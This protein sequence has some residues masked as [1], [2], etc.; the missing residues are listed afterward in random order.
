MSNQSFHRQSPWL[1]MISAAAILMIT[2]G[3]RQS[4][5]LF[6]SPLVESTGLSIASVSFAMAVGQLMWGVAQ[7]IFGMVADKWGI[8][9]VIVLGAL[10]IAVGFGLTPY[11]ES[12]WSLVLTLGVIGASGAGAGSFAIL[13]GATAYQLPP[14]RRSFAGGFINAGGSLGQFMIVPLTQAILAA[15][16]WVSAMFALASVVV[17]TIPLAWVLHRGGRQKLENDTSSSQQTN[18]IEKGH[19]ANGSKGLLQQLKEALKDRNYLFLHAGFFTC[20]FHVAFMVTH[21]PGEVALH[22]HSATISATA[23][24]I[25]GLF[26]IA[27]SLMVGVL[28]NYYRMKYLLAIMYGSRT[29]LIGLFLLAPK[30]AVTFFVFSAA[31]GFTWLA[32]VPPTSGLI[33]KLFGTRYLATL[34]GFVFLTHQIGAFF[35]AWLGGVAV[36]Y[37][38][39]Y[40]WMWYADMVLAFLAAIVTLPIHE[41][42]IVRS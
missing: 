21:L 37:S 41:Q 15:F 19:E 24:G 5:G 27:G 4:T 12:Q 14:E 40:A 22:G 20:G 29:V 11:A 16:G 39:D 3:I 9:K 26:N 18:K 23:I 35:G 13:I 1:L 42:K 31:M 10:L 36:E 7:P 38:G 8:F 28:G 33:A 6:V 2:M 34:F 30:T 25:I 17:F 32:T